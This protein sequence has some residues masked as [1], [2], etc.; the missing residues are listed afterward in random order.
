MQNVAATLEEF[1]SAL[2]NWI[3]FYH[4]IQQSPSLVFTQRSW[5]HVHTNT[6]TWMF[7]AALFVI[8]KTWKQIEGSS[9]GE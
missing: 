2:Q 3:Y 7:I 8:A 1:G 4:M 6:H 9:V 5:K